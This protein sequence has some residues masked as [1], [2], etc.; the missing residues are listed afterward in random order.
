MRGRFDGGGTPSLRDFL[1][2][3]TRDVPHYDGKGSVYDEWRATEWQRQPA[4]RRRRGQDGFEVD[5][6]ALGSGADFVAFQDFLG[7]PTMR[8]TAFGIAIGMAGA[9]AA[10]SLINRIGTTFDMPADAIDVV[11]HP[12]SV[13]HSMVEFEDGSLLAQ[14]G[15]T[16][17]IVH[18]SWFPLEE[19]SAV[20]AS[21]AAFGSWLKLEY[22]DADSRVYSIRSPT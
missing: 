21:L 16:Y 7:L 8:W 5:L 6:A 11:I 22:T 3:V 19:R 18:S 20:E 9:V 13:I 12:Q 2:Q 15:V 17:V 4:E 1:V 10:A 14:L